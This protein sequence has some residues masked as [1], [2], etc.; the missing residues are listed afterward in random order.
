MRKT[1]LMAWWLWGGRRGGESRANYPAD[2]AATAC[3][4]FKVIGPP[5]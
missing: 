2:R 5:H 4:D 3:Y 1:A